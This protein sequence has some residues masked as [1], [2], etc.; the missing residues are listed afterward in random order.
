MK[1][2]KEVTTQ[3]VYDLVLE[4]TDAMRVFS[5]NVDSRFEKHDERFDAH[6][7]YLLKLD[8]RLEWVE[9]NMVTRK[10]FHG[11]VNTVEDMA[12]MM[13]DMRQEIAAFLALYQNHE[14]RI[15][16]LEVKIA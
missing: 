11:L 3:E 14:T 7:E 16:S 8:N 6:E 4:L 1:R 2:K 9:E 15:C 12:T 10:E 13:K 5:N